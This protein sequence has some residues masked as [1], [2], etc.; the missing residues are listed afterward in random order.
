MKSPA[1]WLDIPQSQ[2]SD[3]AGIWDR[4]LCGGME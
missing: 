3:V 2:P 4:Y 1:G